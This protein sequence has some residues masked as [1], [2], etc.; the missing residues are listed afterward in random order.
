MQHLLNDN[1]IGLIV[2]RQ[3]I[4]DNWS[5]VQVSNS[6]IDNRIHYSNKGIPILIPLYLFHDGGFDE[7]KKKLPNIK[8]HNLN[9]KVINIFEQQIDL[10]FTKEK[11]ETENTF[12]P[13]D[14]L[15][16]IYAVLHSPTY[17]ERYKEFL[18]MDF[19]RV[20]YPEN[21][22]QFRKLVELGGKLR[23]LHLMEGVEALKGIGDYPVPGGNIV[24]K[25]EY[26]EGKVYINDTQYFDNIPLTAWN[27]YIGGYQPAQ[28]WL[29]DRKGRMLNFE[30]IVHYRKMI[31]V[32]M[33]TEEVMKAKT[34]KPL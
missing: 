22:E 33:E 26:V 21:T 6:I 25:P 7:N 19:P 34:A 12:A 18:K 15:D 8:T 10:I 9:E 23:R 32:L 13:I 1:N 17:R 31:R 14:I 4:T 27:F 16:Y 29:K 11:E 20:P 30:D 28:K 3:A 2:S 24:E 5:H